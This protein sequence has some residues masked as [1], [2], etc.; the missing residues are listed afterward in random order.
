MIYVVNKIDENCYD[1]RTDTYTESLDKRGLEKLLEI[2]GNYIVNKRNGEIDFLL[3]DDN[4]SK[5]YHQYIYLGKRNDTYL[6]KRLPDR[7]M[8]NAME[9]VNRETFVY[10]VKQGVV[11]NCRFEEGSY[12]EEYIID[13]SQ[14]QIDCVENKVKELN[15]K[16]RLMGNKVDIEC[17]ALGDDIILSKSKIID[18]NSEIIVPNFVTSIGCNAI[19]SYNK[20]I[21]LPKSVKYIGANGIVTGVEV[22]VAGTIKYAYL[23]SIKDINE[24]R[25]N[26][27]NNY[28]MSVSLMASYGLG[29]SRENIA[30]L[31]GS[32]KV[33]LT[34]LQ[35]EF[36]TMMEVQA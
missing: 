8:K 4:K 9:I 28:G 10:C 27:S 6:I 18:K 20:E 3:K 22:K 13:T 5:E 33:I 21:R 36:N 23:D 32:T 17:Y 31:G 14:E 16:V 30:K 29:K 1:A 25:K 19:V 35:E 15:S 11:L 2:E 12:K 24:W 34:K 7:N 26:K